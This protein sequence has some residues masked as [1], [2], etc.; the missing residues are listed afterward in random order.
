MLR[1]LIAIALVL[2]VEPASAQSSNPYQLKGFT[3]ATLNGGSGVLFF[4]LVCQAEF[5]AAARMCTS[6]E[7]LE[8]VVIP[9]GLT[10][11]AWVR[12]VL[13]PGTDALATDA[14]GISAANPQELTCRGWNSTSWPGLY[15]DYNGQFHGGELCNTARSVSCCAPVP[16][17]EPSAMLLNGAG[18][19]A[20]T[21]LS[22]RGAS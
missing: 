19:A 17:P 6:V 8:T 14:S 2:G 9:A 11:T 1:P 7:V 21:L 22:L 13:S 15:V 10:G 4:N 5:G 18:F 16:L 3:A 20:L 12:P